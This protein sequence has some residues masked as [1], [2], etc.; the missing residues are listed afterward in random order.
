MRPDVGEQL[1]D[2]LLEEQ[3]QTF[4]AQTTY[5]ATDDSGAVIVKTFSL[6]E[7][8]DWK[9]VELFERS[10]E[11]LSG[12]DLEGI[13]A[14]IDYFEDD[15]RDLQILVREY[16]PGQSLA[17]R[18]ES[19][20]HPTEEELRT[21]ALETL[22]VLEELHDRNPPIIHRDI[23]PG[24]IILGDDGAVSLIDFGVVRTA[25]HREETHPGTVVGTYG[26]MAPEQ[27]RGHAVPA[28]DL[29][30]LG[31]TLVRVVTGREPSE[32]PYDELCV[33]FRDHCSIPPSLEAWLDKMLA[34]TAD[35]RFGSAADARRALETDTLADT[36]DHDPP[37]EVEIADTVPGDVEAPSE[38]RDS[39]AEEHSL[40]PDVAA[41]RIIEHAPKGCRIEADVRRN[42]LA[43]LLP[44]R[45]LFRSVGGILAGV[46]V[47]VA[48]TLAVLSLFTAVRALNPGF[49]L[50]SAGFLA[51]GS[52]PLNEYE[53]GQTLEVG[54]GFLRVEYQ[55]LG[56]TY[57][58]SIHT[59]VDHVE[60]VDKRG[61][62]GS[63]KYL[64]IWSGVDDYIDVGRQLTP[65]ELH[66]FQS[67]LTFCLDRPGVVRRTEQLKRQLES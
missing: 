40:S 27:F 36:A 63:R 22:G 5:Y 28:T 56:E 65:P 41:S 67:L 52:L 4:G 53:T 50:I 33:Q 34:P 51:A 6:G 30:G 42:S 12:L 1:G 7:T 59:D 14:F 32:L 19:G 11:T 20:W 35:D 13:P 9:S 45:G 60:L 37:S 49:L 47:A 66:W 62:T 8:A 3:L 24:N 23:K 39:L 29:Y 10:V 17:D 43:F 46:G 15:R 31:A 21:L 61:L 44:R 16:V 55:I 54:E 2:Y 26:Y 18:L 48:L 57:A 38:L 25:L 58:S 64:R